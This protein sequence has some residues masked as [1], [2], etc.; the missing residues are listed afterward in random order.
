MNRSGIQA[1]DQALALHRAPEY[2]STI[3]NLP[4]PSDLGTL[5]RIAAGDSEA[6]VQ[7]AQITD[8]TPQELREVSIF[9]LQQLL[10][11]DESDSYRVL[12]VRPDAPDEQI[13][14]HYRWLV[15]W[16]HP[17][18]NTDQWE[19]VFADRVNLAWQDL[20]TPSRRNAYDLTRNT[21]SRPPSSRP[22]AGV[23]SMVLADVPASM[24]L[25]KA[26]VVRWVPIAVLGSF[27]LFAMI[28][29]GL[30]YKVQTATPQSAL[31]VA[32]IAPVDSA[33]TG[34]ATAPSPIEI[35][36]QPPTAPAVEMPIAS[37]PPAS[38]EPAP[39]ASPAPAATPA[40]TPPAMV[41]VVAPAETI[42]APPHAKLVAESVEATAVKPMPAKT[43]DRT[44]LARATMPTPPTPER[45]LIAI[46]P[47][48]TQAANQAPQ[49]GSIHTAA[50]M[51]GQVAEPERQ[52]PEIIAVAS[53]QP[54]SEVLLQETRESPVLID[55]RIAASL[56][57]RFSQAYA[58]GDIEQLMRLFTHDAQ[59]GRGDRRAIAEDYQRLFQASERR[60]IAVNDMSWLTV[61]NGAAIIASFE[62][63][64]VPRGKSRGERV[65][66]DIRFDLRP[67]N[68]ELRIYRVS[69]G[70]RRS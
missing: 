60:R 28:A 69:H 27:G 7:A 33:P 25:L 5:L 4:L 43:I 70:I 15:R 62:S 56:V 1:L 66:G 18:R 21:D 6:I 26:R 14:L 53:I 47:V 30:L 52:S 67:E 45:R 2:L 49:R 17:D 11:A 54:A 59:N 10:F 13:K 50:K 42:K 65:M 64:V 31:P 9:Y 12:G 16:L 48:W 8:Q 3:R 57:S 22:R 40:P 34:P 39:A 36:V 32:A 63:E 19:S 24:P 37:T 58:N 68:G 44:V 61:G 35:P 55:D 20:R 41:E 23:P 51:P 29:L 38:A 46:A